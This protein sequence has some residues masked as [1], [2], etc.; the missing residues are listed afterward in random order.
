MDIEYTLSS[1]LVGISWAVSLVVLLKYVFDVK[2]SAP[3]ALFYIASISGLFTA[4]FMVFDDSMVEYRTG[5]ITVYIFV[6]ILLKLKKLQK[7][8]MIFSVYVV[9]LS[10]AET[11]DIMLVYNVFEYTPITC[12]IINTVSMQVFTA[13]ACGIKKLLIRL[14]N[15][16]KTDR[17]TKTLTIL[18]ATSIFLATYVQ[19]EFEYSLL[20]GED[21][22]PK[23][24]GLFLAITAVTYL[25]AAIAAMGFIKSASEERKNRIITEQQRILEEMHDG[26]RVFRHNYKNTLIAIKG[27]CDTGDYDKLSERL[28]EL[29]NEMDDIYSSGQFRNALNISDAGFRNLIM[30]KTLEARKR[31]IAA[32]LRV[33]GERF[34]A[35]ESMNMLNAVGALL[36]NAIE[37]AAASKEKYIALELFTDSEKQRVIISNSIDEK[38]DMSRI[39][40]KDYSTK[41]QSGLG[42]YYVSRVI[43]RRKNMDIAFNCSD[44]LFYV[45][46]E[47]VEED[48]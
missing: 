5:V 41:N 23:T 32:E 6:L 1:V 4:M 44:K 22:N 24:Y 9:I 35:F 34:D 26:T 38:P 21:M 45:C 8:V 40:S 12:F 7:S 46:L 2:L 27:Y 3:A 18:A 33:E 14:V 25:A 19:L 47:T 43:A 48:E 17:E 10:A 13:A 11:V 42:L 16:E 28:D 36:D 39:M 31:G 15:A 30:L 37:S 20:K 29:Y